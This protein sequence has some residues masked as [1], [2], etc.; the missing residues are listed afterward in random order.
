MGIVPG[1]HADDG[2]SVQGH[3]STQALEG[4][5]PNSQIVGGSIIVAIIIGSI[6]KHDFQSVVGKDFFGKGLG[7]KTI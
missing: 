3:P 7:L 1:K 6:R 4:T 2:G 5:K